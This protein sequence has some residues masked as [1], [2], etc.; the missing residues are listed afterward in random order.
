MVGAERR[1]AVP[2]RDPRVDHAR[3]RP[4]G[5]PP[6]R[7]RGA[8]RRS[9]RSVARSRGPPGSATTRRVPPLARGRPG[10]PAALQGRARRTC[11]RGHRARPSPPRRASSGAC[12]APAARSVRSRSS[13]R[14]TR[15]SP[16]T[17]RRPRTARAQGIYYANGYD[18]PTPHVHE[19]RHDDLPRGGPGPPLP[20][21]ARDGE[22][23]PQHVPAAR[24]ADGRR[25]VRRG[26]GPVQRAAG[27]RD[28]PLPLARASGSACS[29][30]RPGAPRG[31]WSTPGMHA[32]RWP[33]Q[34]SIDFLLAAG[35]SE[36]DAV[37]ETDRYICWPGQA[38][39]Y[40]IGQR[41]I[42]RL[43]R[44]ADG[45]RRVGASICAPSTTRCWA[46]ARCPWRRSPA[47]CRTG[48]PPPA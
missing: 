24:L 13:R 23:E 1:G 10:Q 28:G 3:A 12:R 4:G 14:R 33:R 31:S 43:R 44:R 42:E 41:E 17:T 19:A 27:R 29:T 38:L 37:I 5:G 2:D 21:R 8:R 25:R 22:P 36:T 18:L 16:T 34:Q 11:H 47:S 26:L 39:T 6:D 20:D 48:S 40:K 46:T 35:L 7:P 45:A 9:T 15:R 32:L 30:R